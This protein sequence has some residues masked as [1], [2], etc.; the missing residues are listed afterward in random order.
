MG[1]KLYKYYKK[2]SIHVH[3]GDNPLYEGKSESWSCILLK[4][5]KINIL[6]PLANF[7]AEG[8][9]GRDGKY[10]KKAHL[11]GRAVFIFTL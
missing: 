4:K 10:A 2:L 3:K 9:Q 6:T 8:E 5:G 11:H 1:S 7:Q